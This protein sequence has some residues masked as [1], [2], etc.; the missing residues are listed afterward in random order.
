[1]ASLSK[2]INSTFAI[3]ESQQVLGWGS[4]KNG[5]LGFPLA[6]GKIYDLPREVISLGKHDIF[7]IAAGPFHTLC[8]TTAGKLLSMGNSKDGKLGVEIQE[9]GLVDLE[10]PVELSVDK[11][12]GGVGEQVQFFCNRVVKTLQK[13]YPLFDDY[14]DFSRVKKIFTQNQPY[15]IN[16]IRCGNNFQL[17]LTNNGEVYAC[18]SNKLGQLGLESDSDAED[19]SDEEAKE[20]GQ[21][22]PDDKYIPPSVLQQIQKL[23]KL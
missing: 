5:K 10:L 12:E 3:L 21:Q 19:G 9:T 14:D 20:P 8:L 23:E 17:F 1:M 22:T 6:K 4:S 18:G 7:Q 13:Q 15:E 2:G 11:G 16:Q